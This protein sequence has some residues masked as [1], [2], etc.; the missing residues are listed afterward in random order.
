MAKLKTKGE[1]YDQQQEKH[2]AYLAKGFKL[3]ATRRN[4]QGITRRIYKKD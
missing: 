3:V 1:H 2:D 4:K